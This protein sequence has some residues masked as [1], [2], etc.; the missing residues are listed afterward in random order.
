MGHTTHTSPGAA[1][2]EFRDRHGPRVS[3]VALAL[4]VGASFAGLAELDARAFADPT[5]VGEGADSPAPSRPRVEETAIHEIGAGG[6]DETSRPP[7]LADL[8][9]D[10][11]AARP[12]KR[13]STLKKLA[14]LKVRAAWDL[15]LKSLSD[16]EPMVADE[17]QLALAGVDEPK[18][19]ADLY[20]RAGLSAQSPWV[21]LRVAEAFGR[22]SIEADG[23]ALMRA[24]SPADVELARTLL[25]SIERL[26]SARKLGGDRAKLVHSLESL[27][28]SKYDA[29]LRGAALQALCAIDPPTARP[30]AREALL[31]RDP[32]LRCAGLRVSQTWTEVECTACAR[33]SLADPEPAVRAQAIENLERLS[34]KAA[35]LTLIEHM[36]LEARRRLRYGILAFLQ[37][38]SGLAHEFDA[39]AWK[40]WAEQIVGAVTTG[41]AAGVHLGPVGDT[42]VTFAGL[43]VISDRVCFL[44]DCS[45]S[46]WQAKVGERTRKEIADEMLRKA[47]EALPADT[48]FNVIPYT[49]VPIPWEKRLVPSRSDNVK[50]ALDF[51][52]RCHRTGT[53]NFYDAV[54]LALS[55]PRVDTVVVLSDG[56]PTGGHRWNLDLMFD[57]LVEANRFRKVAFDS[58]LV[59]APKSAQRKWADLA[60][61][62]GGRS[63]VA[64]LK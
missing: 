34:S 38:R 13:R 58:I 6:G 2:K 16:P 28:Q 36:Q 22:M 42:R 31:E 3:P 39:A 21:R 32:V 26:A 41:A 10:L 15:V 35:I 8:E 46:L 51:F 11:R 54:A 17:A 20:G 19:L 18:L 52:E 5:G 49:D 9:R 48:E 60:R 29:G 63:I 25:W 56:I 14:E 27:C 43:N 53:G 23:Q 50:R 24:A 45:G 1:A 7:S 55:D 64:D 4:I 57:L 47:L 12:E 40:R 30:I 61:R 37:Q 33:Q 59:D 44:I 62:T